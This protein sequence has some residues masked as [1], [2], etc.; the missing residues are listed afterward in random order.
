[1]DSFEVYVVVKNLGKAYGDTF[2][3][4]I[5]RDF[6][7]DGYP[8]TTYSIDVSGLFYSDTFKLKLPVDK[9]NGVGLNTFY[10]RVD[11]L[12]EVDELNEVNNN[13]EVTLFINSS[14]IVPIYPYEYAIV[15][16]L[17]ST[18]KASTSDP[19][20]PLTKYFFQ[21]D[22]SDAFDGPIMVEEIIES[23]GGVI[24]WN[25]TESNVLSS[26]YSNFPNL[27]NLDNPQVFF[28]RVSSDSTGNNGFSWKESTFQYVS[29][30]T[31]WGQGHFHQFKKNEYTFIDY[32]YIPIIYT[33]ISH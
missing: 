11:G 21:I 15:P 24:E 20:A 22:T 16:N 9:I 28:W 2:D 26:F 18:L 10:I 25:P 3:L 23:N 17:E 7:N 5:T 1:M 27:S 12:S 6:P 31:G 14:D 4:L 30:K 8:D 32:Q 19:Y 29:D 33:N 13:V